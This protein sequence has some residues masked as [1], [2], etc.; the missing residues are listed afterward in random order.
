[1]NGLL[2]V[3]KNVKGKPGSPE[4]RGYY[5]FKAELDIKYNI[6]LWKKFGKHGE[7]MSGSVKIVDPEQA[8][9]AESIS[10]VSTPNEKAG[11]HTSD[12]PGKKEKIEFINPPEE[13]KF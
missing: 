9:K 4:F 6:S 1:M 3:Y 13:L 11:K 5:T 8:N 12:K 10:R 7:Y 2:T